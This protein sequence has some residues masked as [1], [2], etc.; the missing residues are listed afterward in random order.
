MTQ[1]QFRTLFVLGPLLFSSI[2][3]TLVYGVLVDQWGSNIVWGSL[4][5]V[6]WCLAAFASGNIVHDG[7]STTVGLLWGWLVLVPL[8]FASGWLWVRLSESGRKIAIAALLLSFLLAVPAK[9]IMGWDE[10]GIHLP[11]YSLH[12]ATSY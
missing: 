4:F 5:G 8:Y 3:P 12:L 2:V 6:G 10:L 7:F 1:A 11:D 9:T